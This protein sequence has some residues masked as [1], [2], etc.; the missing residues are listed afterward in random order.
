MGKLTE[1]DLAPFEPD[2]RK[3]II[4]QEQK[5]GADNNYTLLESL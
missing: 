3:Y 1:E 4:D 5:I 2:V